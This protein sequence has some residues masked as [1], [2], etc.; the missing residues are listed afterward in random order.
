MEF[1]AFSQTKLGSSA[2]L[3]VHRSDGVR[4]T[5]KLKSP[6]KNR[7]KPEKQRD[8]KEGGLGERIFALL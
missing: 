3:H 2:L 8:K 5:I 1:L 4:A 6:Q 7:A